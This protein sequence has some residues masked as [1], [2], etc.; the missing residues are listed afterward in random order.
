MFVRFVLTA[1][2]CA[3][4]VFAQG[5]YVPQGAAQRH[6][7]T[8]EKLQQQGDD[9][10]EEKDEAGAKSKYEAAAEAFSDAIDA[11]PA[12]LDA[13]ARYGR[14]QYSLG[15]YKG[16]LPTLERGLQREKGSH[17]L[18]FWY[19]QNLIGAG[20]T[21]E[22]LRVLERVAA[23]TDRFPE[24]YAVLGNQYYAAGAF[25][26]AR[27]A[28]TRFLQLEP[29]S[30]AAR[31]KL[32][33]TLFK[34]RQYA[35]AL[36]E[37]EAVRLQWPDNALVLVNI[38]N[39]HYQ[40][41]EYS[42][43]VA[44][45]KEALERDP[46][47]QS[48]LFNLAQS[49]FQLKDYAAA[50][51]YYR[52]FLEYKPKS[53]N[54]RYF[55]GSALMELGRDD[56]ALVELEAAHTLRPEIVHPVY[57][58]GLI[59]LRGRRA[60]EA[61]KRLA[62]ART[63]KPDDAWVISA[64][65]TLARQRGHFDEAAALH[66]MAA[67][68][69]P[70][71]ARLHAN[72]ALTELRSRRDEAALASIEQALKLDANDAWVRAA[73]ATVLATRATTV[74]KDDRQGAEAL[75]TRA[76]ALR[77][78]DAGLLASRSLLRTEL[79]QTKEAMADARAATKA[80]P[81]AALARYALGRALFEAGDFDAARTAFETSYS[82]EA[83]ASAAA[84]RSAT[85]LR[86]GAAEEAMT[87]LEAAHN[88]HPDSAAVRANRAAAH[89]LR[90]ARRLAKGNASGRDASDLRIALAAEADLSPLAAARANYAALVV[91]LRRGDGNEARGYLSALQKN[92]AALRKA[93]TVG[94]YTTR[95]A[96][97]Q[98]VEFLN[99][100]TNA[101]LKRYDR[102]IT[103][104]G[105]LRATRNKRSPESKLER[106]LLDRLGVAA[107][108]SGK[109]KQAVAHLTAAQKIGREDVTESN[110]LTAKYPSRG[111]YEKRWG[112]LARTVNEAL[113]NLGVVL[114]RAGKH[115]A[116][117][118]AYTG[119]AKT[120]GAYSTK[121]KEVADAKARIFGFGK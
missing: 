16:A 22:G 43:S 27:P 84:G 49:Y 41:G 71:N 118:K 39:C 108:K 83:S 89:Y 76:I 37:F 78:G 54:G 75:L 26:R 66:R 28:F 40:L 29:D 53:F 106:W 6:F 107:F 73:A 101:L 113:F 32:G 35:K 9:L 105:G 100:M 98:H 62:V 8:G 33:N 63:L 67:E 69:A 85:L 68:K 120:G 36:E 104:V 61:E 46:K 44:L 96:G 56:E 99:A 38:G 3:G 51:G 87:A 47:R 74:G 20:N 111:R 24:V 77:P 57:K 103:L 109:R 45:L 59:H 34:L 11:E 92:A 114:D 5:R 23:E 86:Q 112:Q 17:D 30:T 79:R 2:L 48:V 115:E 15:D 25:E 19:G 70:D 65:G 94:G 102:A 110:L 55:A 91:A 72:L 93:K 52:Q 81:K 64:Q 88:A 58:L 1:V 82:Q 116:A 31:A 7:Q 121:A 60:A 80:D 42:K 97:P 95:N 12:Y 90:A 119:Y 10:R 21:T 50:V 14:V 117:W 13:Y 4:F 18:N